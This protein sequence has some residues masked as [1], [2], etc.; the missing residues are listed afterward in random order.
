M[1]SFLRLSPELVLLGIAVLVILLVVLMLVVLWRTRKKQD[2]QLSEGATAEQEEKAIAQPDDAK[3]SAKRMNANTL[4]E[5]ALR[6]SVSSALRFLRRN[7][8]GRDFRYRAPWY[9]VVGAANSG[10]TTMLEHSGISLSLREGATDFGVSHG[11]GWRFFDGGVLLDV[12]G[13]FFLHAGR[14]GSDERSWKSLL[15]NLQRYRPGRPLDGIVLTL[16][17]T[18]LIGE[19]AISPAQIGQRAAQIVDKLWQLEQWLGL[20]LPIYVVIT[21]CDTMPGFNGLARQLPSAYHRQMFGWSNPNNLQAAFDP[22]WIDQGFDELSQNLNILQSE[23]FVERDEIDDR[24]SVFLFSTRLQE[25]RKPLRIYLA[26]IFKQPA[27]RESHQLRGFYF[28]GDGADPED[29][30]EPV[31]AMAATASYSGSAGSHELVTGEVLGIS[32]LAS[33]VTSMAAPMEAPAHSPVFI[34]DLFESKIFQEDGLARPPAKLYLSRDRAV[35]AFQ[36]LTVVVGIVLALGVWIQYKRMDATKRSTVPVL[37]QVVTQLKELKHP[38]LEQQSHAE[39]DTAFNLIHIMQA[40]TGSRYRTA[41]LP[42]SYLS[43]LDERVKQ[44]MVPAF[45]K[46]VY[47]K[48]RLE[49]LSRRHDLL[50]EPIPVDGIAAPGDALGPESS[51]T[52]LKPL[53]QVPSYQRLRDYTNGLLTLEANIVRYNELATHGKGDPQ[54]LIAL[55]SYLHGHELPPEFDYESNP[56]FR[57]ALK[58]ASGEM[59]ETDDH[60]K[61]T[62]SARMEKLVAELFTQWLANNQ[63]VDYLDGLRDNIEALDKQQLESYADLNDL[64]NSLVQAQTVLGSADLSWIASEK[65]ASETTAGGKFELPDALKQVTTVPIQQSE[66]LS[67]KPRLETF[68]QVFGARAFDTLKRKLDEEG[69]ALTGSLLDLSNGQI[70]LS[71]D[72]DQLRTSLVD[73][74]D[75]PYVQRDPIGKIHTGIAPGEQLIWN[76]DPLQEAA[77]LKDSYDRF[78]SEGLQK[79]SPMLK[80]TLQLVALNRLQANMQA[81]IGKAELVQA[82]AGDAQQALLAEVQGFQDASPILTKL[83]DQFHQLGLYPSEQAL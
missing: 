77:G 72:A 14:P 8:T 35:I 12:P 18:E 2:A 80:S 31:R 24:D 33:P 81:L 68:V 26:Q 17:C 48:F 21:K 16:P 20:C 54:S 51:I 60:D 4:P 83:L 74:L 52:S 49:L 65:I 73:L 10:K 42:T 28:V 38:V 19:K 82:P 41:F 67:P 40:L 56:Y 39:G 75:V 64:K 71:P 32:P 70:K 37:D 3:T 11:V 50:V 66:Y 78:V 58:Q 53:Q 46:L 76:K 69:T 7:S 9:M 43:P 44:A 79:D 55:E 34:T 47:T 45:E 23:V 15:R 1:P 29:P 27:Y 59:I 63:I 13:D 5:I 61:R 6:W 22:S 62:A 36:A 57:A 30:P 25:L